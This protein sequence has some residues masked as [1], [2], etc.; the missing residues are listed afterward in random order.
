MILTVEYRGYPTRGTIFGG[1]RKR[2]TVGLFFVGVF[3]VFSSK[4]GTS[5][6]TKNVVIVGYFAKTRKMWDFI[7]LRTTILR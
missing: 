3:T 1:S 5:S 7:R 2:P 6:P 4:C